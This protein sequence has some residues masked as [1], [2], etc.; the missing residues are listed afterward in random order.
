[1]CALGGVNYTSGPSLGIIDT[2]AVSAGIGAS[3]GVAAVEGPSYSIVPAFGGGVTF[4]WIT[5]RIAEVDDTE[6]ETFGSIDLGVGFVFNRRVSVTPRIA[7]PI[8][9]DSD[10]PVFAISLAVNFGS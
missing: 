6:A 10:D 8:G 4:A 5:G 2:T 9:R 3:I 7:F 1:V